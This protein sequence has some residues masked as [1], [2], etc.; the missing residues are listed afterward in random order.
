MKVEVQ[1]REGLFKS[2]TV[3]IEGNLVKERID[4]T[5]RELQQNV[6]IQGFRKG[7]A[8]LW[9]IRAKYRDYV[10]EEV[11][12]KLA[13]ETLQEALQKVN[14]K[15][16]ADVYLEKV[17]LNEDEA[18]LTYT[19]SFEVPPEFELKDIKGLE[20][21][22][23][24]I[25]YSEKMLEEELQRLREANAVWEPK[26]EEEG[27][28]PGDL[29]VIEYEVEEV[30]EEGEKVKQETSVV[31]GQG[32]L[33]PEV[34]EALK[35]KK[36]GEEVELKNL[37]L[38]DQEGKE[39]GKVNIRIKLKEVKKKV[40]PELSDEFA[41]ELGYESLEALK[42][43][44]EEDIKSR[45]QSLKTQVTEDRVAD[46]LVELH[47]IEIPQ[48]LLRRELSF[49]IERRLRELQA[50]GVDPRY[51][52]VR[53]LAE[54]LRPVAEANIK[55][56]FIL[57][58]YAQEKGIEPTEEDIEEQYRELAAQYGTTEE[59]V[60]KYFRERGLEEVV[61]EDARRKKALKEI[62]SQVK[63]KEV[64]EKKEEEKKEEVKNESEGST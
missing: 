14:L 33:R 16:V 59:E 6:Q 47:D 24:K 2:L 7:K 43:K 37:P 61:K 38:Y 4:Q 51:V 20:V 35:G 18:K 22:V 46:K 12:K 32:M 62:I 64:E 27:A 63:I 39:I 42:K 23:P 17:E 40:L 49:L 10:Q 50:Y 25:E 28:Q 26:E 45:L 29:V 11:G 19:V 5:Y 56:R 57:D 8:P 30:G 21:E 53:K 13:D 54:E 41:Q 31:L 34:E 55:L 1:D 3:E 9:I 44:V 15:P 58:K 60:K 48:T 52:D 36:A